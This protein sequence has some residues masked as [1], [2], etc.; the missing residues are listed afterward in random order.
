MDLDNHQSWDDWPQLNPQREAHYPHTVRP[1]KQVLIGASVKAWMIGRQP[2]R[3]GAATFVI[4]Q[5]SGTQPT[6]DTDSV[7]GATG[8]FLVSILRT[9]CEGTSPQNQAV[10][11]DVY[12]KYMIINTLCFMV[13][14]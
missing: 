12:R 5:T 6:A 10:G 14:K 2:R 11:F 7:D 9:I 1:T 3:R 8:A 13:A 4:R